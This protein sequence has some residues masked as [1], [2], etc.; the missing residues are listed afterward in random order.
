MRVRPTARRSAL[1]RQRAYRRVHRIKR[2]TQI[3]P[4]AIVLFRL[5]LSASHRARS[6]IKPSSAGS[7]STHRLRVTVANTHQYAMDVIPVNV[8]RGRLQKPPLPPLIVGDVGLHLA[9]VSPVGDQ[10]ARHAGHLAGPRDRRSD[11]NGFISLD[12]ARLYCVFLYF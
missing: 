9:V 8:L 5:G 1:P 11:G 12:R 6:A 10:H 2:S 3:S 4:F 7:T